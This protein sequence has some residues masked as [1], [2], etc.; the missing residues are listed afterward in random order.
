MVMDAFACWLLNGITS[1]QSLLAL[2]V[3]CC[4]GGLASSLATSF[5]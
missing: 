4:T 3:G 2:L 1:S 5:R